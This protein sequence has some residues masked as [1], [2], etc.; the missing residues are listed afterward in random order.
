MIITYQHTITCRVSII[1]PFYKEPE[2]KAT[3]RLRAFANFLIDKALSE[4]K[5]NLMRF[6]GK[7][8]TL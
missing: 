4:E 8:N 7:N 2:E 3:E 1:N 5:S 6:Q